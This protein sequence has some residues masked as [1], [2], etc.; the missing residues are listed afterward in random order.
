MKMCGATNGFIR[1]PF[2]IEGM[3]LGLTGAV[4]AFFLQWGVYSLVSQAI[5]GSDPIDLI[6]VLPFGPMAWPV[7][8]IFAGTGLVIGTLGSV[9]AIRKFLQV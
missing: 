5:L 6:A 3:L 8:G 7:L 4:L 1:W 9:L 2:V